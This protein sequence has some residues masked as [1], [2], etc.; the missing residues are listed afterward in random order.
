MQ[1]DLHDGQQFSDQIRGL[2]DLNGVN[3]V[4]APDGLAGE[5]VYK[6][7]PHFIADQPFI[8]K[9]LTDILDA[10]GRAFRRP[11]KGPGGTFRDAFGALRAE[12]QPRFTL[13]HPAR[14]LV[15]HRPPYHDF[16]LH[17]T[18]L[19]DVHFD[20]HGELLVLRLLLKWRLLLKRRQ[21]FLEH[22]EG[23]RRL[24]LRGFKDRLP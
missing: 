22:Y 10:L 8:E 6:V 9:F 24:H 3:T 16:T 15:G 20:L 14:K 21:F 13:G 19:F 4:G 18:V 11:G 12:F 17:L 2:G 7:E 5:L 1:A 23:G